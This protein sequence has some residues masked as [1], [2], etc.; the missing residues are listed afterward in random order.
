MSL[1][2]RDT[3]SDWNRIAEDDPFWGVLSQEEFRKDAMTAERLK[4]FMAS[5]HE[6][7]ANLLS[8]VRK[9]FDPDFAPRRAMD[10]GCGVGRLA[11]PLAKC[12]GEVVAI[13]VAPAM[14]K[15]CAEHAR[16]A[17]VDNLILCESDDELTRVHGTFDLINTYIVLQHIPPERGYRI[18]QA[19]L[20]RLEIGGI[21][22]VQVTYA[23]ARQFF[24]YESPKALYFRRDGG[25]IT[26][27]LD[28]G[29]TPPEGTITMFDYDMNQLM[30]QIT[31]VAGAPVLALP[32]NDD[33]H[34]GAHLV[35]QR[36]R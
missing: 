16:L 6:Y 11:I 23:K 2:R 17:D 30:A 7:V 1:N 10:F 22:S 24:T 9:F 21:G 8:F 26:D 19:M 25:V 4:E 14:L 13:D 32:T 15:L 18:L 34:L 12:S 20:D 36:A 28:S 31:R 35:F 33:S 29:W 5:G 3:D 27:I